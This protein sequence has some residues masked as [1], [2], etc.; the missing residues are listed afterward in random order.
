M[1]FVERQSNDR[2]GLGTVV[3]SSRHSLLFECD[4]D[5]LCAFKFPFSLEVQSEFKN[6]IRYDYGYLTQITV[7]S[8]FTG[9][10]LTNKKLSTAMEEQVALKEAAEPSVHHSKR[11]SVVFL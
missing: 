10:N 5:A 1:K 11:A 8:V 3:L 4:L 9:C 2:S 6:R 7:P